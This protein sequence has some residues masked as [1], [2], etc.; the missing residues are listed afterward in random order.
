MITTDQQRFDTVGDAKPPYLCMPHTQFLIN[1]GISYDRAY[2][3]CPMCVPS[4]ISIMNGRFPQSVGATVNT[5]SSRFLG[6]RG[7]LPDLLRD[8]GYQTAAIGKMHFSPARSRHGFDEMILPDDYYHEMRKRGGMLQPMRHGVGQNETYPAMSTV[9]E[10]MTLTSWIT[11]QCVEYI[12]ERRDPAQPFFLWCSYS[13]PHPPFDPPEPYYSMY[14]H[15][16]IEDPVYGDWSEEEH[17][18]LAFRRLRQ[19]WGYDRMGPEITRNMKAAYYGLLTQIDYNMG[20]IFAALQDLDLLKDTVILF[21]SDHG[22][23]LG[24]YH[25]SA[26]FFL[27][28]ASSHVPF[29]LRLPEELAPFCGGTRRDDLVTHADILPT[30]VNLAGGRVPE[31]LEGKDLLAVLRG[32]EQPRAHLEMV[33]QMELLECIGVTDGAF[34]Y[35]YYLEDQAE[36]LFDLK[37]DPRERNNLAGLPEYS[38]LTRKYRKILEDSPYTE[39]MEY[40]KDGCLITIEKRGE[41]ER[42]RRAHPWLGFHTERF[43]EDVKH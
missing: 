38:T 19:M 26:K 27:H 10:A 33:T 11:E 3:Q 7:T 5:A 6:T 28:Q 41:D 18:P 22:E 21:T 40:V 13:K 24:D 8:A 30:L 16:C 34:Q 29:I 4:R 23:Y 15:E 14:Q 32:E 1:Q 9:P 36:Q 17:A 43:E 20:R 2:A 31:D 39:K 12:H 42:H 25:T 37:K 35:I